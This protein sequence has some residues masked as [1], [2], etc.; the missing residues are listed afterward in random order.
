MRGI[1]S[2]A[3]ALAIPVVLQDGTTTAFRNETI[4]LAYTVTLF[5]LLIPTFTLPWLLKHLHIPYVDEK[6]RDES[7]ARLRMIEAVIEKLEQNPSQWGLP[8][9]GIQQFLE[10]YRRLHGALRPNL[11][12]QPYTELNPQVDTLKSFVIDL[13]R[14]ERQALAQLRKEGAI[15]DEVFHHL[16][17]EL[18]FEE[19][20][21]ETSA[22]GNL[23]LT[24]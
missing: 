9:E 18:D 13:L 6:Q 7:H 14:V 20:R 3:G 15:H 24:A 8:R 16:S 19:L 12:D 10:N 4:F 1:V 21:F 11:S 17:Q 22:R 2:L 23:L 5:S